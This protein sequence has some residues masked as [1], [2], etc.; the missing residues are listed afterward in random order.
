VSIL[1]LPSEPGFYGYPLQAQASVAAL[2]YLESF[3]SST[4][5]NHLQR[6]VLLK[7]YVLLQ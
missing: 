1:G 4:L 6:P 7:A 3:N 5:A 2:P